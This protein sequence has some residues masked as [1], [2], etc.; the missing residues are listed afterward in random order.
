MTSQWLQLPRARARTSSQVSNVPKGNGSLLYLKTWDVKSFCQNRNVDLWTL[1]IVDSR[2]QQQRGPLKENFLSMLEQSTGR[3]FNSEESLFPFGWRQ[4]F[5]GISRVL[6]WPS[7]VSFFW[8][9]FQNLLILT[10]WC[11]SP[12][13]QPKWTQL[14]NKTNPNLREVCH[15][16]KAAGVTLFKYHLV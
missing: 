10:F 6:P 3:K 14:L 4:N 13:L 7:P 2:F 1:G 9:A 12:A 8:P 16:H 5:P 15:L 11:G